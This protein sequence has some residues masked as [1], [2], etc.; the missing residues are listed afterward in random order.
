MERLCPRY[1]AKALKEYNPD[2]EL[3]WVERPHEH[4]WFFFQK[5]LKTFSYY[6]WDGKP[7]YNVDGCLG[8]IMFIVRRSDTRNWRENVGREMRR[9]N[10]QQDYARERK[11]EKLME[12]GRDESDKTGD[13]VQRGQVAKPFVEI[14]NNPVGEESP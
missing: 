9:Q 1:I 4:G 14:H 11:T 3:R 12:L 10:W 2:L 5:G 8:E 7:A 6:H 13:F